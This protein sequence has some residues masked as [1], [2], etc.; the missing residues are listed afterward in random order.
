MFRS[1]KSQ[2][3]K[4][5]KKPEVSEGLEVEGIKTGWQNIIKSINKEAVGKTEALYVNK[6]KELVV[7]VVDHLWLQEMSY[8]RDY[9]VKELSRRNK[10]INSIRFI[11]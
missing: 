9:I 4:F 5:S 7:R 8:Q 11:I 2:I 6:N 3:F 10:S 1:I